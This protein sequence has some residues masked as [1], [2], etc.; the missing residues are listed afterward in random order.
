MSGALEGFRVLDLTTVLMGPYATQLLGDMGADVVKVEPPPATP[1][2]VWG[3]P[4]TPAWGRASCTSTV[5]SAA[6]YWT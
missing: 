4:V 3:R 6:S 1:R 2:A 5:T